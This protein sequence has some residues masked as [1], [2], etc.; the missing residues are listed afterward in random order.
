M[1]TQPSG[2]DLYPSAN[3]M[4]KAYSLISCAMKQGRDTLLLRIPGSMRA[5]LEEKY[6]LNA[7]RY[8][9]AEQQECIVQIFW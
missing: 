2:N 6:S 8:V 7:V 9:G 1:A 5:S 4:D 3:T